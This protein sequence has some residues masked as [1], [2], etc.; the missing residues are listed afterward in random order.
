MK[1]YLYVVGMLGCK[2]T[3]KNLMEFYSSNLA[4][5]NTLVP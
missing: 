4:F 1:A 3:T 5:K 2:D